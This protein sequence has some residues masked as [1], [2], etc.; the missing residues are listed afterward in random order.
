MVVYRLNFFSRLGNATCGLRMINEASRFFIILPA[1]LAGIPIA[2]ISGGRGWFGV[3][4]C[5]PMNAVSRGVLAARPTG[6]VIY[7]E[8]AD[9]HGTITGENESSRSK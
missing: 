5:G 7:V 2:I 3:G 1:I 9:P 6:N 4:S 8:Q